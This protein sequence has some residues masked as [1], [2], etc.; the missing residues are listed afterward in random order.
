MEDPKDLLRKVHRRAL[1]G[2]RGG[3]AAPA[4]APDKIA[5]ADRNL[6]KAIA[7]LYIAL[8]GAGSPAKAVDILSE[9]AAML[10]EMIRQI[11]GG[12]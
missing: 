11:K 10:I 12:P 8:D 4:D 7:A 1:D 5:E 2:V 3:D 9:H 6:R